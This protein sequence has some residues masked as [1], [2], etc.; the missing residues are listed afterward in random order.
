MAVYGAWLNLHVSQ[1]AVA[2]T[3]NALRVRT[4][5]GRR[6]DPTDCQQT[7]REAA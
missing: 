4:R 2:A 7:L 6:L 1:H 5:G 3:L